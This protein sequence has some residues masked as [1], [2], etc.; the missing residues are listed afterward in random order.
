[1][2]MFSSLGCILTL[3][4]QLPLA[5]PLLLAHTANKSISSILRAWGH[6]MPLFLKDYLNPLPT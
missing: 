1:M 6:Q 5:P 2:G 3:G 4:T